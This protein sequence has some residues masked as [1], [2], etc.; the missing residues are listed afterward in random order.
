LLRL[1]VRRRTITAILAVSALGAGLIIPAATFATE[2][3]PT[4]PTACPD[5]H[6]PA[7]VQG[8]PSNWK[9]G[10]RAGDYI[11]HDRN[12]WHLRVTHHS[13]RK[14]VFSGRI[15]SSAPITVTGVKLEKTDWFKL[16]DDKLTLTYRF[17]NYGHVDGLNFKTDCA[18][19]LRISGSMAG[20]KLPI[21]RI[22][23]GKHHVH[24]LSNPFV[25]IKV[26]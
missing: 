15:V 5:T 22:W 24:P 2:P 25:V 8:V 23:L 19:R 1:T 26:S 9:S 13:H 11:W 18:Q 21:G 12:G 10:G 4:T 20:K 17:A 3:T 6:W 16:S 7:S 14:V